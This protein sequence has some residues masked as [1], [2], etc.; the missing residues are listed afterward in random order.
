MK[1]FWTASNYTSVKAWV[2]ILSSHDLLF[3]FCW[4]KS[5]SSIFFDFSCENDFSFQ[6]LTSNLCASRFC[7]PSSF[8]DK[9]E[10]QLA[11]KNEKSYVQQRT[12]PQIVNSHNAKRIKLG[13]SERRSSFFSST[14]QQC[15]LWDYAVPIITGNVLV[16]K[17]KALH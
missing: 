2:K 5:I 11:S 4:V 16:N 17:Q 9:E 12:K 15:R 10:M 7:L 1:N 8:N 13:K 3:D 14:R 6:P